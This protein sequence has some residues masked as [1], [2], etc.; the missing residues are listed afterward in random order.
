[1]G[2]SVHRFLVVVAFLP[3]FQLFAMSDKEVDAKSGEDAQELNQDDAKKNLPKKLTALER[4]AAEGE[5]LLKVILLDSISLLKQILI[6]NLF[7]QGNGVQG[8]RRT[9]S[10]GRGLPVSSPPAKKEKKAAATTGTGRRGRPP[11]KVANKISKD[12][13]EPEKKEKESE[14]TESPEAETKAATESEKTEEAKD[15]E[16]VEKE[17]ENHTDEKKSK[18]PEDTKT[19]SE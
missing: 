13:E 5:A 9:R 2:S 17:E 4:T 3:L 11:K 14:R 15:E 18:T 10:G 8:R 16:T 7:N 1:M 19:V 12:A 6:F